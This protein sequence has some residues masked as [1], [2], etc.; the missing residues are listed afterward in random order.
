MRKDEYARMFDV[1][2]RHWW[3]RGLRALLGDVW[4]RHAGGGVRAV[5]DA[6]CGTGANLA[7]LSKLLRP[8]D[9]GGG[10][11][12]AGMDFSLEAVGFCRSRGL[13]RL[14]AGSVCDL[15][16]AAESFDALV[17]CDV[18]SHASIGDKQRPLREAHRVLR[19]GGLLLM[20][21][22]A[23]QWLHSS[24]DVS[25]QMDRRFTAGEI[26]RLLRA[27]GFEPVE[28]FY[29]NSLLLPAIIPVR[30]WR[31]RFPPAHSD[32]DS[33]STESGLFAAVLA[34]ERVLRRA[35][36]LPFGLSVFAV[37]RK[38]AVNDGSNGK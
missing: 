7:H 28:V 23:Y 16:Y 2:D 29:W 3:Y 4:R 37:A 5:L 11:W 30:L 34:A 14:A 19:P 36:A 10:P 8:A 12:F 31:K 6:G 13:E 22:P 15:P 32:L 26:R 35:V 17:S 38:G 33:A 1:E 21:V 27:C 9:A 25:V 18:L 24:H 20:N